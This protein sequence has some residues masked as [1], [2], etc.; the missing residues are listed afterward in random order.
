MYG[1]IVDNLGR[2]I[3]A[4]DPTTLVP[5][6]TIQ[7]SSSSITVRLYPVGTPAGVPGEMTVAAL[8]S[9]R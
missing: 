5:D 6:C 2:S 4:V 7:N 9:T 3:E 8:V 1:S